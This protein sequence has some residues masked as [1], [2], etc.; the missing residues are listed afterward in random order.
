MISYLFIPPVT[1]LNLV[2]YSDEFS[3]SLAQPLRKNG[4]NMILKF[5]IL[6]LIVHYLFLKTR[7]HSIIKFQLITTV[8]LTNAWFLKID[9]FHAYFFRDY[10]MISD[11][12]KLFNRSHWFHSKDILKQGDRI[13]CLFRTVNPDTS[14]YATLRLDYPSKSL[15]VEC[16]VFVMSPLRFMYWK[17]KER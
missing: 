16:L 10:E 4:K 12:V 17:R 14:N 9:P 8:T 6:P 2:N 5:E 3:D 13:D 1:F 15:V 11:N 7:I